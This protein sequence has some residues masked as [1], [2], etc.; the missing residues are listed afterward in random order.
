MFW[1]VEMRRRYTGKKSICWQSVLFVDVTKLPH[2]YCLK[3]NENK[4]MHFHVEIPS[5]S[6]SWSGTSYA[7]M[8]KN[9]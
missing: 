6:L 4:F 1:K 2:I 7:F 3:I 9:A 8:Y 5:A